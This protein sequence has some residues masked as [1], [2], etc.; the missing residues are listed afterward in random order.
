ME[1]ESKYPKLVKALDTGN[2]PTDEENNALKKIA[3]VI[4]NS[5]RDDALGDK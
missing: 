3:T 1:L 2:K 5:Y 4:G